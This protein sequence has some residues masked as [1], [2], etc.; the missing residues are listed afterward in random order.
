M[1][2]RGQLTTEIKEKSQELLGFEI[3][4]KQL[5]LIPY[6]VYVLSNEQKIDFRKTTIKEREI[7]GDWISKGYIFE[8]RTISKMSP[9]ISVSKEFWDFMNQILWLSYVN[10]EPEES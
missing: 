3:N 10:L 9:K 7:L 8:D 5:R 6:I 1:K 2:K 4:Q